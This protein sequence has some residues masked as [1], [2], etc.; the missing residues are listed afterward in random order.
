MQIVP[1]S[2]NIDFSLTKY[3]SM[4]YLKGSYSISNTQGLSCAPPLV[5]GDWD[6]DLDQDLVRISFVWDQD[7]WALL[8][9]SPRPPR[10]VAQ[11]FPATH[12][13]RCTRKTEK[14]KN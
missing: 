8:R 7:L 4:E 9:D 3:V 10:P 1:R 5:T 12:V 14:P 2:Q 11:G 6:Q 13:A